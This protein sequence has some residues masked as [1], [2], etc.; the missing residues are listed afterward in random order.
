[1]CTHMCTYTN[2]QTLC[3]VGFL[4]SRSMIFVRCLCA[5]VKICI[6]N[7]HIYRYTQAN[8]R[9]CKYTHIHAYT[10]SLIDT[11]ICTHTHICANAY[12]HTQT[13]TLT[14]T[15][16]H[17]HIHMRTYSINSKVR[18]LIINTKL[19]LNSKLSPLNPRGC[20]FEPKIL[21]PKPY[22]WNPKLETLVSSSLAHE[23]T[24]QHS[25]WQTHV[26]LF[27]LRAYTRVK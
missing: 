25:N 26:S 11:H 8:P 6:W 3:V 2:T 1:M 13:H 17:T 9:T 5:H 14:P 27:H 16:Q 19:N 10:H 24:S 7:S 20:R 12:S 23:Q 22:I 21:K 4:K 15:H 18:I